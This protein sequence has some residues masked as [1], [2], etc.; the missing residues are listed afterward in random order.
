MRFWITLYS[1]AYTLLLVPW[2]LV[3]LYRYLVEGK[4]IH[5]RQRL[6]LPP[7]LDELTTPPPEPRIWIHA[8]SVGE[9]NSVRPLVDALDLASAQLFISTTTDTGQTLARQLFGERAQ[10]FFFPLDWRWLCR[11]YLRAIGPSV[12]L[13]AETELW[14]GFLGSAEALGIPV[15][16]VN[17]RISDG[18]FKGYHRVRRFFRPILDGVAHFCMQSKQDKIRMLELGAREECVHWMGNLKY[19]YSLPSLREKS[20]AI[21]LARR[22]LQRS[23]ED[24]IWV[25]GSI[26]DGEE[27]LLLE[28]FLDLRKDFPDLRLL[29]APRHLHRSE[30]IERLLDKQ[31]LPYIKRSDFGLHQRKLPEKHCDVM[32]LDSLGEL[33]FFYEL[34]EVIFVGGSF[35]ATGGHN[36]IEA[37]YFGRPVLVGP[38][39]E[40][41]REIADTFLGA[42]AALQ[43][44]NPQQL[45]SKIRDLLRDRTMRDWLGRNAR[46]V[47]RENQGAVERTLEIVREYL[48]QAGRASST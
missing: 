42:Y 7:V 40:N 10:V 3:S 29:L 46:K 34:G 13:I 39:M 6:T 36:I 28:V 26:R 44:E 14:P 22:L 25:C 17:G 19:D 33:P 4:R 16:I 23:P 8:V 48:G 31:G 35:V 32:I 41:F 2:T 37:A 47:I 1:V 5:L 12:V 9:V 24:P 38:H 21:A 18:S 11:R 15:V 27:A 45:T 20:E 43:V 30:T